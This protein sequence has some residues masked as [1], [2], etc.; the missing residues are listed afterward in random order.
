LVG[1]LTMWGFTQI[2]KAFKKDWNEAK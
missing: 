1:A 2:W